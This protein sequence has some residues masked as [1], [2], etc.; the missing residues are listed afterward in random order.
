MA[1][2]SHRD[3]TS[4]RRQRPGGE[5]Q[6]R[7]RRLARASLLVALAGFLAI[8]AMATPIA[9]FDAEVSVVL[10]LTGGGSFAAASGS[11]TA[12]L[13]DTGVLTLT[14]TTQVLIAGREYVLESTA[15]I[16]GSFA[17]PV[18]S[19]TSGSVV[20]TSCT[21]VVGNACTTSV[22]VG[23]PIPLTPDD[24]ITFDL[25]A[26]GSTVFDWMIPGIGLTE[27]ATFTLTKLPEP[28]AFLLLLGASVGLRRS[29]AR[30]G[31]SRD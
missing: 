9:S 12:T 27:I 16:L 22:A 21:D 30:V 23:I 14:L 5:D 6:I 10:L 19:A 31:R 7:A 11:G 28:G 8:P 15:T 20:N 13:D 29:G 24:P 25:A 4:A 17:A 26:G 1:R 2:P 18:L 3:R